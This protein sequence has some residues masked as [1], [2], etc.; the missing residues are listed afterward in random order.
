MGN[1]EFDRIHMND[2]KPVLFLFS[3]R[4]SKTALNMA[5]KNL[6]IELGRGKSQVVC[7]ALHPGSF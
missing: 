3:Y 1:D 2:V 5:T 7:V 4:L 6:S